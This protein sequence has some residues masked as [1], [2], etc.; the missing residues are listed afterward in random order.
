[1]LYHE[2]SPIQNFRD[3]RIRFIWRPTNVYNRILEYMGLPKNLKK[4]S[5]YEE[6]IVKYLMIAFNKVPRE[7]SLRLI[8][9]HEISQM[10]R[11]DI[12]Y[13]GVNTSSRDLPTE[14]GIV[15]N[16]FELSCVENTERKIKKLSIEDM[17][18]QKELI[19]SSYDFDR[20][21]RRQQ[22]YN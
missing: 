16:F 20:V 17:E 2:D 9:K 22:V 1:L 11:S 5:E 12:P 3:K 6:R 13:F 15:K 8:L 19:L 14:N 7:S 4:S 18:Y 21:D 10:L